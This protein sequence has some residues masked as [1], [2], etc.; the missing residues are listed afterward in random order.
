MCEVTE[1]DF[2]WS[3]LSVSRASRDFVAT[4]SHDR[5][6]PLSRSRSARIVSDMAI[7]VVLLMFGTI[8]RVAE[9]ARFATTRSPNRRACNR[10][11]LGSCACLS[12]RSCCEIFRGLPFST[13][14]GR[15]RVPR[16]DLP[17][18][19]PVAC[20]YRSNAVTKSHQRV[21][22]QFLTAIQSLPV[23]R[24]RIR[25]QLH[26]LI[27]TS[28]GRVVDLCHVNTDESPEVIAYCAV[29]GE[30]WIVTGVAVV[31]G[32]HV[33][34]NEVARYPLQL[35]GSCQSVG[36]FSAGVCD[37]CEHPDRQAVEQY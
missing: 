9:Q 18:T 27:E 29:H 5:R 37:V 24:F 11:L 34:A 2:Y 23:G 26:C 10:Q 21:S 3:L 30:S 32:D 22:N 20:Q 28:P 36:D 14:H 17:D 19:L 6:S 15:T 1:Q 4:N 12:G 13:N 16:A 7:P 35:V 25:P 8:A 31:F 33:P